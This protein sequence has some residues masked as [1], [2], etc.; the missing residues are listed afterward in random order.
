MPTHCQGPREG[1][2]CGRENEIAFVFKTGSSMGPGHQTGP[3]SYADVAPPDRRA[4]VDGGGVLR[5]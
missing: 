5:A 3:S 2:I 4:A 1:E